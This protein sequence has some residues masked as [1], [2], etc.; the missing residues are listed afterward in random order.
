MQN[1]F[2]KGIESIEIT[3]LK[4]PKSRFSQCGKGYQSLW[5]CGALLPL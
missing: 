3:P 1:S 2:F 5:A 4:P